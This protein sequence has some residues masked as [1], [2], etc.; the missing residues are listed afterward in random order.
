MRK[1]GRT[2]LIA[3]KLLKNRKESDPRNAWE[4][5]ALEV[6]P[7]SESSRKKGCP[8]DTFLGL[9]E[10]GLIRNVNAGAFTRSDKN[11]SYALKALSIL[12]KRPELAIDEKLLWKRVM[13]GAQ[14]QEN[15][16]MDIVTTLWSNDLVVREK[17]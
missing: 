6:F 11:K 3:V 13:G 9:C 17:L 10:E 8:R 12:K 4:R 2:S 1:Y 16:Q 7:D 5:A 14:K 15:S